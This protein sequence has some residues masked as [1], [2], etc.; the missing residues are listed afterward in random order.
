MAISFLGYV[1]PWGQMSFWGATV[2]TNLLSSLPYFGTDLVHWVWGGFSVGDPSLK[3]FLAVHFVLPILLVALVGL[4][5][6]LLHTKG[7]S[8]P[9][10]I[11]SQTDFIPFHNMYTIKDLHGF[12]I[13]FGLLVFNV[14]FFPSI[15]C[16]PDNYIPANPISTPA[17]IIPEWYFL[18]AY[19]ILR[20]VSSKLG[21]V[22]VMF[23]SL[24]ILLSLYFSHYQKMVRLALY[25]PVKV[26][27][28]SFVV[29]FL[30]LIWLGSCPVVNPFITLRRAFSLFYFIFFLLLPLSRFAWDKILWLV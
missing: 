17:H 5:L 19:A 9:L 20:T 13:L 22:I 1:L 14:C 4:H 3:R 10:G 29:S 8:T 15:F 30:A 27:F 16:E 2:I 21:G 28:W 11:T 24:L 6:L 18:H 12:I 23:S 25:G 7:R 26:L